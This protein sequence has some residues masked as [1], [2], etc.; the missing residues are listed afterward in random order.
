L[1]AEESALQARLVKR[2]LRSPDWESRRLTNS[3][4]V[5]RFLDDI[6]QR[7]ARWKDADE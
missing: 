1:I 5:R 6:K 3:A 7:V 2:P 4:E